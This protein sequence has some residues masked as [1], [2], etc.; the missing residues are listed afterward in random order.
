MSWAVVGSCAALGAV[1]GG[2]VP[3][4]A[5]RLS[6]PWGAPPRGG[7]V[8]C[9]APFA[10][11]TPGWV[12]AGRVCPCP[13]RP[14][15]PPWATVTAAGSSAAVLGSVAG[16][17]GILLA[18]AVATIGVLLAVIDLACL[19]LPDPLV[20]ALALI[21]AVPAVVVGDS[22][23]LG[24]A[25]LAAAAVGAAYLLVLALPGGGLGF[26]DVKL[27][28]VLGFAL[29][30]IGWPAVVVGVVA[31]H[32]I[33][34]PVAVMLLLRGRARRRT[35]L[36][37]GPALLAGALLAVATSGPLVAAART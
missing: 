35:A 10:P 15:P 30:L 7:C 20:G 26:G 21:V 6:V 9:A 32:L 2:F 18:V 8:R 3:R 14:G 4:V 1:V 17:P 12:R 22:R 19:R 28:A 23:S 16:R 13:H 37:L 5:Y 36:P 33:N 11:G 34:G 27:A 31:P 24:R 25:V 29:G